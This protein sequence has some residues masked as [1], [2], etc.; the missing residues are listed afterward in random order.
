MTEKELRMLL[1]HMY[2]ITTNIDELISKEQ[3]EYY[4]NRLDT[5]EQD[6]IK[7]TIKEIIF[8]L[9]IFF[10][11]LGRKIAYPFS[12]NREVMNWMREQIVEIDGKQQYYCVACKC[13]HDY[14]HNNV[15]MALSIDHEPPLSKRFN[16]GEWKLSREKRRVSY[17][18]TGRLQIMC[19]SKN[20]SKGGERYEEDK[21]MKVF[22]NEL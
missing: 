9:D 14:Q 10:P 12:F 22:I 16:D 5:A 20:S 3:Y 2:S 18:D 13:Y 17:N 21:L 4:I 6:H 11:G 15:S 8:E 1:E 7:D 19:Q